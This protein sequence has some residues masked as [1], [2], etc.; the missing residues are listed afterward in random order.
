MPLTD[1]YVSFVLAFFGRVTRNVRVTPNQI[2]RA[3]QAH[4]ILK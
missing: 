4:D 1:Q 2:Q 3:K